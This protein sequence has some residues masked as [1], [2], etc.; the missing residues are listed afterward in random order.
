MTINRQALTIALDRQLAIADKRPQQ[1]AIVQT[2][3]RLLSESE[4]ETKES[5]MLLI[6]ATPAQRQQI[7]S[8]MDGMF[9]SQGGLQ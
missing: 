5:L 3:A 1:A 8:V 2:A 6:A 4:G 9:L 7:V